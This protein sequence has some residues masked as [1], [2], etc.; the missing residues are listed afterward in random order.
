MLNKLLDTLST[1]V[2]AAGVYALI[3]FFISG[4]RPLMFIRA[5]IAALT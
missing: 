1:M 2:V 3:L 5:Y 4:G